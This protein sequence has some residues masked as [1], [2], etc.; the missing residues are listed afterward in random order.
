[1]K[2]EELFDALENIDEKHLET[3]Y[4]FKKIKKP[5]WIKYITT[6]ACV[7]IIICAAGIFS[8]PSTKKISAPKEIEYPMSNPSAT[9]LTSKPIISSY[10]YESENDEKLN[11]DEQASYGEAC[12][13]AP[14][15]GEVILSYPLRSA[16]K[17]HGDDALYYV[18][19]EA[20]DENHNPFDK[21]IQTAE[22]DRLNKLGYLCDLEKAK[23]PD[24]TNYLLTMFA[25]T[26]QLQ[27]FAIN[28]NYGYMITLYCE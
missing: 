9:E 10:S 23:D 18:I 22:M 28:P 4:N 5:L 17:K 20:E 26:E 27:N 16:I 12:Y 11:N 14:D 13:K 8:K 7:C 3:A 2:K 24:S 15:K 1:M 19:V 6:A 21:E 25:T